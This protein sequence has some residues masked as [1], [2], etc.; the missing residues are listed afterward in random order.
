MSGEGHLLGRLLV[1]IGLIIVGVGAAM[2]AGVSLSWFGRLPGDLVI[3]RE[4][5]S[6]YLPLTS[7]LVVSLVISL[8]L[9][10]IG[11]FRS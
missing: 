5:V 3:R 11:R 8:M 1:V 6:V 9:W 10:L 4:H 2:M 7:C